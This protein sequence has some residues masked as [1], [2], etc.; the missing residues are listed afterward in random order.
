MKKLTAK[1]EM[2]V[3][4]YIID[5]N[6]TQ[7]A[8]RSGYSKKTAREQAARMLSKVNIQQA[9]QEAKGK[10]AERVELQADEVLM[11]LKRIT[12]FNPKSLYDGNGNLKPIEALDDDTAKVLTGLKIKT[13]PDG[14]QYVEIKWADRLKAIETAMRHLGLFN[15][16]LSFNVTSHEDALAEL[17]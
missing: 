6:A 13:E 1:Q 4:E 7:A 11:D 15:D 5:L 3:K 14:R 8:I 17:E 9:I 2:F 10:R 12:M 16:K